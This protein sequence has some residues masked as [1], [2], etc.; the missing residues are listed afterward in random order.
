VSGEINNP[1]FLFSDPLHISL[2]NAARKL[3]FGILVGI[4][5]YKILSARGVWGN[6]ELP[7][8]LFWDLLI[9]PKLIEL[10]T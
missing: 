3:K 5:E 4:Y 2:T 8:F 1:Q 7:F 6:Q 10:E 9:S